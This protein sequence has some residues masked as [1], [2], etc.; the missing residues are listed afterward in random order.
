MIPWLA[1][2]ALLSSESGFIF[3]ISVAGRRIQFRLVWRVRIKVVMRRMRMARLC[4]V[5]LP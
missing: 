1:I 5:E 3:V 2:V 4:G